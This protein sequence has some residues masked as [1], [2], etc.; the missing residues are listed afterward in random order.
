MKQLAKMRG[1]STNKSPCCEANRERYGAEQQ[2]LTLW[3]SRI[4]RLAASHPDHFWILFLRYR[5]KHCAHCCQR[6]ATFEG[7]LTNRRKP[8][9]AE[10]QT[11]LPASSQTIRGSLHPGIPAYEKTIAC[12]EQER[13]R[14]PRSRGEV[15][16]ARGTPT[17]KPPAKLAEPE[18]RI[19]RDRI[20]R[21]RGWRGR[22]EFA[23]ERN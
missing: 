17:P 3:P 1:E 4:L 19:S 10:R 22:R 14:K 8:S 21:K 9:P 16:F 12:L 18:R 5:Y 13:E 20:S 15:V 7:A 23:V 11:P 2:M 6:S